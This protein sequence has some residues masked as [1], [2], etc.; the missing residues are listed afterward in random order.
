MSARIT[1]VPEYRPGEER[2]FDVNRQ[3]FYTH[4]PVAGNGDFRQRRIPQVRVHR[5]MLTAVPWWLVTPQPA[6]CRFA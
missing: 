1:Q 5:L 4:N 2:I 6:T 3:A